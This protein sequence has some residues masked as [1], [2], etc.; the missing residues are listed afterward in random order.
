MKEV[1][2]ETKKVLLTKDKYIP[3]EIP[4]LD[5][6]ETMKD[7]EESYRD[8]VKKNEAVLANK[9]KKMRDFKDVAR[10]EI[11]SNL[12]H[13][14]KSNAG[15]TIY[16]YFKSLKRIEAISL[17]KDEDGIHVDDMNT[18]FPL[19]V[20]EDFLNSMY[21]YLDNFMNKEQQY[22]AYWTQKSDSV[23]AANSDFL[24]SIDPKNVYIS[25]KENAPIISYD[26]RNN[27]YNF[28]YENETIQ[29]K[30]NKNCD[31]IFKKLLVNINDCPKWSKKEL[32]KKRL[33][34]IEKKVKESRKQA[35]KEEK[36]SKFGF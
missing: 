18:S 24:V 6:S 1:L 11:D 28:E 34:Q 4:L 23:K 25:T 10:V 9:M 15:A 31:M 26:I 27:R 29:Y 33:K 19:S 7:E 17:T 20:S 16:I 30:S 3:E 35:K 13:E 36:K 5:V 2:D 21:K 12:R 14:Q 32:Y 8:F 22:K